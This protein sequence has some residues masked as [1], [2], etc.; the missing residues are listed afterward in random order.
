MLNRIRR[1]FVTGILVAIPLG[2][3]IAILVW[4]FGLVDNILQPIIEWIFG[5]RIVG[6]GFAVA[7]GLIFV[8]GLLANNFLG[9]YLIRWG[10]SLLRRV[11]VIG[12]IYVTAREVIESIA[13]QSIDKAAFK[14]V[15]L[16]EFPRE[17][18]STVAFITKEFTDSNGEKWANIYIPTSP[19]PTSGY[20]EIVDE[21]KITRTDISVEDAL[22]MVVSGGVVS[23]GEK[24]CSDLSPRTSSAP[25]HLQKDSHDK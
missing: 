17:G 16:V 5:R 9:R 2:A 18:M 12:Q 24:L 1:H 15:V 23:P 21:S 7:V 20:F 13:G 14:E 3:V 25:S 19:M 8:L 22:K 11:P 4:I 10:E 6:L